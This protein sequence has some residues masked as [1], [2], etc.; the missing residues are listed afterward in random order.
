MGLGDMIRPAGKGVWG[1]SIWRMGMG[2]NLHVGGDL[3]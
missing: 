3:V 2:W 1:H